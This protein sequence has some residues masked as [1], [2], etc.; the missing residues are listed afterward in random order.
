MIDKC[1]DSGPPAI[2]DN[3]DD[4]NETDAWEEVIGVESG[5]PD[6]QPPSYSPPATESASE[7]SS[8]LPREGFGN[9]DI[10]ATGERLHRPT[11]SMLKN[12][13]ETQLVKRGL[14]N[15]C[16]RNGI[17]GPNHLLA[18]SF[19]HNSCF[20]SYDSRRLSVIDVNRKLR[21]CKQRC[22]IP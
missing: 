2:Q 9:G 10:F 1:H 11:C 14:C 4:E 19:E 15:T 18:F 7:T 21:L 12:H 5:S 16:L 3:H 17:Q 20:H 22:H 8:S 13:K 6:P